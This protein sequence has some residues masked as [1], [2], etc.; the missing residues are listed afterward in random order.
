MQADV[1]ASDVRGGWT[2]DKTAKTVESS[3]DSILYFLC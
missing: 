1:I 3:S 2:N